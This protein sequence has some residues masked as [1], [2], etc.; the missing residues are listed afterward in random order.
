MGKVR[1]CETADCGRVAL[2]RRGRMVWKDPAPRPNHY[3]NS[4]GAA[5]TG[6]YFLTRDRGRTPIG[7]LTFSE[8]R[9]SLQKFRSLPIFFR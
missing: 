4:F 2:R 6:R 1:E 5:D 9:S 8:A 3:G 7:R